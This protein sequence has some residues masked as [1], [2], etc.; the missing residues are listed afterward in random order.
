MNEE[1]LYNLAISDVP[2]YSLLNEIL[3]IRDNR[4]S[5]GKV[6]Y[7]INVNGYISLDVLNKYVNLVEENQQLKEKNESMLKDLKVA[8]FQINLH[9]VLVP[10]CIYEEVKKQRDLYKSVIDE[11]KWK[12][13]EEYNREE[14]DWVLVK[15]FDDDYECV[16]NVAEMRVDRKWYTPSN[17]QIIFEIKYFM[18]MQ[19]LDKIDEILSKAKVGDIK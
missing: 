6:D 12:P 15:Y 3:A 1:E 14:Y 9:K 17:E 2:K 8:E 5:N 16:P 11:V 13:I 19:V 10:E 18:D 4:Y 7:C